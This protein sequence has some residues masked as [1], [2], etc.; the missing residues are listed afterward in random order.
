MIEAHEP[1]AVRAISRG[2]KRGP[3]KWYRNLWVTGGGRPLQ[4]ACADM[5]DGSRDTSITCVEVVL[6]NGQIVRYRKGGR[7]K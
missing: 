2:S 1:V 4:D 6:C 3:D 7:A 5:M